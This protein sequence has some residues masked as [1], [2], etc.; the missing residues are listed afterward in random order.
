MLERK[1]VCGRGVNISLG[2]VVGGMAL[3]ALLAAPATVTAETGEGRAHP[4]LFF[5]PEDVPELRHRA[6]QAPFR[7]M[8]EAADRNMAPSNDPENLYDYSFYARHLAMHYLLSGDEADAARALEAVQRVIDEDAFLDPHRAN[9]LQR[10]AYAINVALVY[11]WCYPAWSEQDRKQ[12][13]E[14][15]ASAGEVLMEH[16][17]NGWPGGHQAGSNWFAVRYSAAGLAFL[18]T[19]EPGYEDRLDRAWEQVIRHLEANLGAREGGEGLNPEGIGYLNYPWQYTGPFGLAMRRLEDRE[20]V[21]RVPVARDSLRWYYRGVLPI[22]GQESPAGRPHHGLRADFSD[23]N[24]NWGGEGVANLAFAYL[25]ADDLP[26]ARWVYDRHAG[27]KGDGLFDSR[28]GSVIWA[29]LYYPDDIESHNPADIWGLTWIDRGHGRVMFRDRYQDR[30]D[31][32]AQFN[33]RRRV[34][35]GGHRGPDGLGVR[36][37]G[38]NTAWVTGGGRY[39]NDWLRGQSTLYGS[40]PGEFNERNDATGEWVGDPQLDPEA[41]DGRAAGF[42]AYSNTGVEEHTRRFIVDYARAGDS[43][44]RAVFIIGDQSLDG[45]WWRLNTPAFNEVELHESGFTI[46]SP[47]GHRMDGHVLHP[48]DPEL[49]L[50]QVH[51]GSPYP[52]LGEDYE[53]NHA[54][55]FKTPDGDAL[56]VLTLTEAGESEPSVDWDRHLHG[57]TATIGRRRFGWERRSGEM[58]LDD[59]EF[60]DRIT[61]QQKPLVPPRMQ[62]TILADRKVR[63][64]WPSVEL[65]ADHLLLERR[66]NDGRWQQHRRLAPDATSFVDDTL[67]PERAYQYRLRGVNEYGRGDPGV[68]GDVKAWPEGY[69]LHVED[70]APRINGELPEDNALGHWTKRNQDR[71][72]QLSEAEGSPRHAVADEGRMETAGR[73]RIGN[74]NIFY[75]TDILADLSGELAMVEADFMVQGTTRFG[76]MLR[77]ADGRWVRTAGLKYIDARH[78]WETNRWKIAD[79][80]RWVEV[81]PDAFQAGDEVDLSREAFENVAGLGIW[82]QWPLNERW[83]R[84]D[85]LHL[86]G[87]DVRIRK[88]D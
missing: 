16:G 4:R 30:D 34:S 56:V 67:E 74:Q 22:A 51:R 1:S 24:P 80:E 44:A 18:A 53:H 79:V 68:T 10:G 78:R 83:A 85:Q 48:V 41:G 31:V 57:V 82:G 72:W 14:A 5:G 9:A 54:V 71:G 7:A 23:D 39:H 50:Q 47:D 59:A 2:S 33:V 11:D 58:R 86:R 81:D 12:L 66:S 21:D 52:Y 88:T 3:L 84:V 35:P 13:S 32:V 65:G 73:T 6:G 15:L 46:T 36:I 61:A 45:A 29:L 42:M 26:A 27:E 70:F 20:L 28:R 49:R 69:G 63:L 87:R 60:N 40:D 76:L 17:G 77:L 55:D 64:D 37:L 25:A 43:E 8:L 19:D 38:L 75:T 62:V